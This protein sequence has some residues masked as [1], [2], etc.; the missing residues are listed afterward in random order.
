MYIF[1]YEFR[2]IGGGS[3]R[4]NYQLNSAPA[5]KSSQNTSTQAKPTFSN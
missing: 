1:S 4:N 2:K 5:F 3:N